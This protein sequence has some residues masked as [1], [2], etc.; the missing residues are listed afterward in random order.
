MFIISKGKNYWGR[1]SDALFFPE[2]MNGE[3]SVGFCNVG[4][5]ATDFLSGIWGQSD[6]GGWQLAEGG[7]RF[8]ARD[9][10]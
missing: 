4:P 8:A 1:G 3:A 9:S 5:E 10:S 6:E 2:D 7:S